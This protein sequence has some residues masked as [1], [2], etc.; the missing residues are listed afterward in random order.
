MGT[1]QGQGD[2]MITA[3]TERRF[4]G[5]KQGA[6]VRFNFSEKSLGAAGR[7]FKVAVIGDANPVS[8]AEIPGPALLLPVQEGARPAYRNRSAAGTGTPGGSEI[9]G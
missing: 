9:V 7:E 2:E 4:T 3:E 8:Q 1:Q 6:V 5:G